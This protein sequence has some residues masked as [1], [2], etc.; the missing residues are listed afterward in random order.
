MLRRSTVARG[1]LPINP[2]TNPSFQY[3]PFHWNYMLPQNMEAPRRVNRAMSMPYQGR[4]VNKFKGVWIATDMDPAFRVALEPY[5]SKLPLTRVVPPTPP[6][7]AVKDFEKVGKLVGDE[8]SRRGWLAKVAHLCAIHKKAD[9]VLPLWALE[10]HA[11]Y[12]SGTAVPPLPLAQA[13]VYCTAASGAAEWRGFFDC[14]LQNK[15]NHT[16][17]FDLELWNQLLLNIGSLGDGAGVMAVLR[18]MI[19]VQVNLDQVNAVALVQALNA[20]TEAEG[21]A[22]IKKFLFLL[23]ADKSLILLKTYTKLRS[24]AELKTKGAA[25]L[26][27]NDN[28]F[29]HV[30]WHSRVRQPMQFTPRQT[31]FD[32]I[33]TS[34][35][36]ADKRN[37][38][39]SGDDIVKDKIEKWK[40]EGLLPEDYV[41]EETVYDKTASFKQTARSEKWKKKPVWIEK[42][43]VS[44]TGTPV[45]ESKYKK[46]Y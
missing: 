45:D 24:A 12:V 37:A 36:T 44:V 15:W 21:Y 23:S 41:H 28:M 9:L 7:E 6:T 18:E 31:Y 46:Q 2:D 3:S 39:K 16:P 26:M 14:C 35:V 34:G 1:H 30:H 8:R 33:P 11:Q 32:Y 19:D 25:E 27:V 4:R 13:M 38:R 20:V 22:E 43:G 29:H 17:M 40:S 5:L 10:C 42:M